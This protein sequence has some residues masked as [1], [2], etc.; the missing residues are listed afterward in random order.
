MGIL[1]YHYLGKLATT[2]H[3]TPEIMTINKCS[4]DFM[5]YLMLPKTEHSRTI[6]KTARICAYR[7]SSPFKQW[8]T[9]IYVNRWTMSQAQ[10][11]WLCML[12]WFCHEQASIAI[13]TTKGISILGV[14]DRGLGWCTSRTPQSR[15]SRTFDNVLPNSIEH[16]WHL[17]IA[18]LIN[19]L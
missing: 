5:V 7:R 4:W 9:Y 19:L 3:V 1:K 15:T 2:S 16:T 8:R 11:K 10:D 17:K 12:I 6:S 13:M 14:I 18:L